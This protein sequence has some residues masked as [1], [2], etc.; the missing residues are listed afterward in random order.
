[1]LNK[2]YEEYSLFQQYISETSEEGKMI[3]TINGD[4]LVGRMSNA[5]FQV[6]PKDS[7]PYRELYM[8]GYVISNKRR[9]IYATRKGVE[10]MAGID[11]SS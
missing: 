11:I 2:T 5:F 10:R 9:A 7:K 8:N 4:G 1:M 3:R 6:R